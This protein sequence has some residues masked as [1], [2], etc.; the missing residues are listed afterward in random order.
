MNTFTLT[1]PTG[2]VFHVR[3]HSKDC[4]TVFS[5]WASGR[6]QYDVE[7]FSV[8]DND[9]V[10][11]IGAHIGAVSIRMATAAR[12][13]R[14]YAF[15]PFPENFALLEQN[16]RENDLQRAI[17]PYNFAVSHTGGERELFVCTERADAHTLYP[18]KDFR[19]GKPIKVDCISLSE[20]LSQESIQKVDFLKIDAEGAE[21]DI[22]LR[23]DVSFLEKVEKI[24]TEL[25]PCHPKYEAADIV[26]VLEESGFQL[27][28]RDGELFAKKQ[29]FSRHMQI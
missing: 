28:D 22:F 5:Y 4:E 13:V 21:Y 25:H 15:E 29:K 14:V 16:I 3:P 18:H 6:A 23:G 24:A 1:T 2:I 11:D 9:I 12:D 27:I 17:I 20:F 7:G 26:A 8:S 19:F 10:I